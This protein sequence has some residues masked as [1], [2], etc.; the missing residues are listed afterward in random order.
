MMQNT[1]GEEVVAGFERRIAELNLEL[2]RLSGIRVEGKTKAKIFNDLE[3]SLR[4]VTRELGDV[5][6][7]KQLQMALNS[8]EVIVEAGKI[9]QALPQ[10][11]KNFGT[12]L[13]PIRMGNGT[14]VKVLTAYYARACDEKKTGEGAFSCTDSGGSV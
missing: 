7:A 12:R 10:N 5:I 2:V 13:T 9:V 14:E 3:G 8:Q 4:T 11:L 1:R 6:A